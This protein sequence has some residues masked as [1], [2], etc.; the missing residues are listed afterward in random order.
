MNL[1]LSSI[2]PALPV[3]DLLATPQWHEEKLASRRLF[4][5]S[6]H[7]PDYAAVSRDGAEIHF[8]K[9]KIE[10]K[11]NDWMCYRCVA[12]IEA[13]CGEYKVPGVIHP[14]GT[15]LSFGEAADS[16]RG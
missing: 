9:T 3:N 15:L 13:R 6:G 5:Y 14:N 4:V 8:F 7:E 1:A 11:K 16:V 12:G 10:P 2:A